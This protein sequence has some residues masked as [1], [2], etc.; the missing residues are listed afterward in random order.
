MACRIEISEEYRDKY[1][2]PKDPMSEAEFYAWL[3]NG[4]LDSIVN[5]G[6]ASF[7]FVD[8]KDAEVK[9]KNKIEDIK[10]FVKDNSDKLKKAFE[11]EST[12]EMV[13]SFS[14]LKGADLSVLSLK[15]LE[16][17]SE[18]LNN[19]LNDNNFFGYDKIR[20]KLAQ[21]ERRKNLYEALK[22]G[23]GRIRRLL[24]M[25]SLPFAGPSTAISGMAYGNKSE[26]ALDSFIFGKLNTKLSK[27]QV[28]HNIKMKTL[29][30][31]INK[32]GSKMLEMSMA[33]DAFLFINQSDKGLSP[34]DKEKQFK[35]DST[36]YANSAK[37]QY[38]DSLG[39]KN[40]ESRLNLD[41]AKYAL[42]ALARF[43]VIKNLKFTDKGVDF[44]FVEGVTSKDV[45]DKLNPKEQDLYDFLISTFKEIEPL[46]KKGMEV[47]LGLKYNGVD[48]YFPRFFTGSFLEEEVEGETIDSL[49][50][51]F[52]VVSSTQDRAKER[53]KA[54]GMY[55][56]GLIENFS[57]GYWE[58]LLVANAQQELNDIV[59]VIS[60]PTVGIKSLNLEKVT[61]EDRPILNKDN[62][63]RLERTIKEKVLQELKFG[64]VNLSRNFL[65]ASEL[66]KT[67]GSRMYG[68]VLLTLPAYM[69]QFLPVM[70]TNYTINLASAS[71]AYRLVKSSNPEIREMTSELIDKTTVALREYKALATQFGKAYPSSYMKEFERKIVDKMRN[72]FQLGDF[73]KTVVI[74]KARTL[75]GKPVYTETLLEYGDVDAS[76]ISI[77][78]GYITWLK[79]EY[80]GITE[81]EII[82]KLKDLS[83]KDA[84][85]E[86]NEFIAEQVVSS[87]EALQRALNSYSNPSERPKILKNN[88]LAQIIYPFKTFQLATH[89]EFLK[90]VTRLAFN[91]KLNPFAK[92]Y[93]TKEEVAYNSKMAAVYLLNQAY[94]RL[95][96]I[97]INYT[98]QA[99]LSRG[100]DDDEE[101]YRMIEFNK[102]LT[103]FKLGMIS[104][105]ALGSFGLF[106]DI[107]LTYYSN[108]YWNGK[109]EEY[110]KEIRKT[111][112]SFNPKNTPLDPDKSIAFMPT[113]TG[114]SV[115]FFEFIAKE[116]KESEKESEIL[117]KAGLPTGDAY[118]YGAFK[119]LSLLASSGFFRE[120]SSASDKYS[121]KKIDRVA[122]LIGQLK[123]QYGFNYEFKNKEDL[124]DLSKSDITPAEF[125]RLSYFS[126]KSP[127]KGTLYILPK[128]TIL[129]AEG[130]ANRAFFGKYKPTW[131]DY[132]K[133]SENYVVNKNAS[134][135]DRIKIVKKQLAPIYDKILKSK[136]GKAKRYEIVGY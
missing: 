92:S 36:V 121:D 119:I 74:N 11:A 116:V 26:E 134:E 47:G 67:A 69:K 65:L 17:L 84:D 62:L 79:R 131:D 113:F 117:Q 15:E 101:K 109:K 81:E 104:D 133:K 22:D 57:K 90:N 8:A 108:Y 106:G 68:Y 110:V 59:N 18:E 40:S 3:A 75:M 103:T 82:E 118:Y 100:T 54:S 70:G 23:A 31:K 12:E 61:K 66:W 28:F 35:N 32:L 21:S 80:K 34:E 30:D 52:S 73:V 53:K 5:E 1:G 107:A 7:S 48:N 45:Q 94:F 72:S 71:F 46:F 38:N 136:L 96:T 127:N 126:L 85:K 58:A 78:V 129:I 88:Y 16:K 87:A 50:N 125:E 29:N 33:V 130:E 51:N 20:S 105:A 19:I 64:N 97:A 98:I 115:A 27:I 41:K 2:L 120:I 49:L 43:G 111:N 95:I 63:R 10:T 60:S 128:S 4:G 122:A 93:L 102:A 39:Y 83:K 42:G 114:S 99:A 89:Q 44:D 135:E 76:R 132:L 56:I 13:F 25:T 55:N 9:K 124:I 14:L 86:I 24:S 91:G 77:I 112:P 123:G 6:D 37:E